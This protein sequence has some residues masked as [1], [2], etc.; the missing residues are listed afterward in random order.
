MQINTPE[1]H[2]ELDLL[3][4]KQFFWRFRADNTPNSIRI[5]H[6]LIHSRILFNHLPDTE[7]VTNSPHQTNAQSQTQGKG[8]QWIWSRQSRCVPVCQS[9]LCRR[10]ES[11][12]ASLDTL[13]LLYCFYCEGNISVFLCY[14]GKERASCRPADSR[15]C[16]SP[17]IC[18]HNHGLSCWFPC[19]SLWCQPV[20]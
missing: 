8:V 4:L 15:T 13:L 20:P 9:R 18:N 2:P 12:Q 10:T 6:S 17:Q 14:C 7:T 1:S 11:Q 3:Y 5:L 19:K 16:H